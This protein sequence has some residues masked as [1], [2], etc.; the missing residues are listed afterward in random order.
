[1]TPGKTSRR[2][3]VRLAGGLA[4][5]LRHGLLPAQTGTGAR[6]AP[7][8]Q[9]RAT[10]TVEDSALRIE[11]DANLHARVSRRAGE[12]WIP[13]TA[14]GPSEYLLRED[15]RHVADFAIRHQAHEQQCGYF[16]FRG[17]PNGF[18]SAKEA[19]VWLEYHR[20]MYDAGVRLVDPD[21]THGGPDIITPTTNEQFAMQL[22][23]LQR[24][25]GSN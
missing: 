6:H 15:G 25:T 24:Y 9:G 7:Q 11:W 14:W 12:H 18:A 10:A 8:S 3:F 23:D 21:D 22:K 5:V 20:H 2:Q 16:S 17:A 1:M 19:A 13:M 4:L